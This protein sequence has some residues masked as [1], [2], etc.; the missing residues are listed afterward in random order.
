MTEF[1]QHHA[2]S[3]LSQDQL[4]IDT[5]E[6]VALRFP[7]AGVGSRFLAIFADTVV[8][9]TAYAALILVFVLI[10]ASA[11]KS[12]AG[13]FTRSGEKWLIAL[14]ILI[15]FLM[16]WG[17]FALFEAFKNGQ[18]PG[19]MLFKL[20]VI[21]DSGR[22]ITFFEAMTRNLIRVI[23]MIPSFYL[24][25]VISMLCNRQHKRLGDLAAGTLVVHERQSVEM[26][27]SGN[28]ARTFTA[29]SFA[30]SPVEA[31][32]QSQLAP[33]ITLPADAVARLSVEDLSV[34]ERFFSRVLDMDL[35]T[36]ANLAARLTHQM[37]AKM[38]IEMPDDWKPERILEAIVHQM[39][40]QGG[41]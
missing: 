15:H 34:I 12:I 14:V 22:Q 27:W 25:G 8:Q 28:S 41:R 1:A 11:P 30:P 38:G 3:P 2:A 10:T 16:Y 37:A 18:T 4:T 19:K 21:Q 20:R 5:P 40:A 23:D 7:V 31:L 13:D 32:L 35:E 39:R 9:I 6:Q 36:R 24:V 33:E 29:A 17:Y 26:G